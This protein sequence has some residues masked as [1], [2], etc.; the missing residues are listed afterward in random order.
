MKAKYQNKKNSGTGHTEIK[1]KCL[2]D[3]AWN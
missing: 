3:N 2:H 1:S